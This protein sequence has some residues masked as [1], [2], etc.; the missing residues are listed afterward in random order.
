MSGAMATVME[1]RDPR[2]FLIVDRPAPCTHGRSQ[3][4][5]LDEALGRAVDWLLSH[6]SPE[7]WWWAE[8]ESNVTITAEHLFLTHILGIGTQGLWEKIARYILSEQ[9][10]EGFWANWHGGPG[11]LSTTVE[12]YLALKM[13]GVDPN[14]PAMKKAREWILSQG[15]GGESPG[16]HEDLAFHARRVALGSHAH[17]SA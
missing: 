17:A 10:P 2:A 9:R 7:G 3:I 5:D 8:L 11:D 4:K 13:T 15:G 1:K 12:A 14:S 16:L 6:Q